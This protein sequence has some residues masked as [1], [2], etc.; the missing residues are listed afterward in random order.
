M[1]LQVGSKWD[2]TNVL[3]HA[4]ATY[5]I[6]HRFPTKVVRH[7]AKQFEIR[8]KNDGC[9]WRLYAS[10][11]DSAKSSSKSLSTS[12]TTVPEHI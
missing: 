4:C 9:T 2:S 12:I 8:C 10:K 7:N 1:A 11:Y 5:A 3:K 6:E